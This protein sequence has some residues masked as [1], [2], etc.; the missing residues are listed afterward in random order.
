MKTE[1]TETEELQ[2]QTVVTK[3]VATLADNTTL[4]VDT[5]DILNRLHLSVKAHRVSGDNV[6]L[7]SK[8]LVTAFNKEFKALTY[9]RDL[10]IIVAHTVI[11]RNINNMKGE[12]KDKKELL[13]IVGTIKTVFVKGYNF[14]MNNINFALV[15][16]VVKCNLS[17]KIKFDA[18]SVADI[19]ALCIAS[20]YEAVKG[21]L[22]TLQGKLGSD[23][24]SFLDSLDS[25]T[26]S[27]VNHYI[28][29]KTKVNKGA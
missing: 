20:E 29:A 17:A 26:L 16:R 27:A 22:A 8:L 11:T 15:R 6:E 12:D 1:V 13:D 19:E 4:S 10:N 5:Q 25:V 28:K 23:V 21:Q 2:A 24:V 18:L 14:N 3:E 9:K 7:N